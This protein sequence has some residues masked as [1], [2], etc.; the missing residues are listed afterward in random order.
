MSSRFDA[1]G[2]VGA[3]AAGAAVMYMLDPETGR[4]RR[5]LVRDQLV[6]AAHKT[7][8]AVD[9][10]SRDLTNRARGVVA[11]LRGRLDDGDVSDAK[12]I[13]RVRTRVGAVVGRAPSIE[14]NVTDGRVTLSGPI[15]VDDIDLLLRRVQSVRG[16]KDVENRLE[17][18]TEPG[19]VPGL[20]GRP[21]PPRGGQV[22]ELWQESWSP[23][24]R[25]FTGL[26]GLGL[27][28]SGFG[29]RDTL[30]VLLAATGLG[31]FSRAATN[32]SFTRGMEMLLE[33]SAGER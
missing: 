30:G 13:E 25:F 6:H 16:V 32:T 21:R 12:L 18:H 31:L 28:A 15:L 26:I 24:A 22:F 9:A 19:N 1:L 5:A 29:R 2:F 33:R 3:L 14:V 8:D 7:S 17:V 27:V 23:T 4:R 11:E 10:T 20:Q